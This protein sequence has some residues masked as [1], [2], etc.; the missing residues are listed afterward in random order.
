[1]ATLSAE[2]EALLARG[3][4]ALREGRPAEAA[5]CCERVLAAQPDEPAALTLLAKATAR[6][7]ET[8]A[9]LALYGRAAALRPGDAEPRYEAAML[10]ARQD[11]LE[12]TLA[13]FE[14]A[15][16]LQPDHAGA[17]LNRAI[18]LHR[19]GRLAE[20]LAGLDEL[21]RLNPGLPAAWTARAAVLEAMRRMPAAIASEARAAA[22]L[23][24][25]AAAQTRFASLLARAGDNDAARVHFDLALKLAPGDPAALLG[26][27]QF[28]Q[29]GWRHEEAL[30]DLEAVLAATPEDPAA[31]AMLATSLT[32]L[33][34]W[35]EARSYHARLLPLHDRAIAERPADRQLRA[36]RA[37][38]FYQLDRF[39]EALADLEA[40]PPAPS[41]AAQA[42]VE[43]AGLLFALGRGAEALECYA[44]ALAREPDMP[45][46]QFD[47]AMHRLALGDLPAGWAQYEWRWKV[48][49]FPGRQRDL[50]RPLWL[51]QQDIAGKRLLLH[52]EQGL[53]DTIQFCRYAALAAAR[54]AEVLL[55]VQPSLAKLMRGLAGPATILSHGDALPDFDLHC[56]LLSLPLAFGT[57]LH[58]I[59]AAVP[60]LGVTPAR[61]D[62]WRQ[63]LG[64]AQGVRVGLVWAGNSRNGNDHRRSMPLAA[65]APLLGPGREVFG[66]MPDVPERDR[67]SLA[68]L[69][70]LRMLGPACLDFRD[71]AA[72]ISLM[73][74]VVTVDTVFAHLAG[75]LG[76]PVFVMLSHLA[77]WRWLR[78][79]ADSPWYPTAR[80]FRQQARGDWNG[81]VQ[82]VAAALESRSAPTAARAPLPR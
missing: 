80:L 74:V 59:P 35:E 57:Q 18:A 82:E 4:A 78:D 9:A 32:G 10:L 72:V 43:R 45:R 69:P 1:M 63:R 12:Q 36:R 77:D 3:R 37:S 79:R 19:L 41:E 60:Y 13:V 67:A 21:L 30:A 16:A 71:A 5:S 50:P 76:K 23:P 22:L 7:G 42:L 6:G 55:E 68:A 40:V 26:R 38:L 54:G 51:G 75:A 46:A 58:D 2:A 73:D 25:K 11:R 47:M 81:V 61:L 20:A 8:E 53:G 24:G 15:L 65:A 31:L 49:D 48:R 14:A 44:Q 29:S 34:R 66:L 28:W 52:A 56:P 62:A 27:A 33:G 64:P 17:R 39:E 70:G